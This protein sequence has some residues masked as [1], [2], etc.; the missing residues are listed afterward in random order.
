MPE[1]MTLSPFYTPI[2]TNSNAILPQKFLFLNG[3]LQNSISLYIPYIFGVT[4]AHPIYGMYI[5]PTLYI[6]FSSSSLVLQLC[7]SMV[8]SMLGE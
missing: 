8:A 3:E 5:N 7:V 2:H 1:G 6:R 4:I